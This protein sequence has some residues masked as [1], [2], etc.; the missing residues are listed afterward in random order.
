[1]STEDYS[2]IDSQSGMGLTGGIGGKYQYS[3]F[4][5]SITPFVNT[6]AIIPFKQVNYQQHLWETGIRFG[7][8]YVF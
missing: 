5:F 2:S 1:M 8:G 3:N 7:V 6:H 4:E